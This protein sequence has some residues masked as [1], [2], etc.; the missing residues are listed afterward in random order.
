MAALPPALKWSIVETMDAVAS[1]FEA[2]YPGERTLADF[3]G[4]VTLSGGYK[5]E[6]GTTD[7]V[8]FFTSGVIDSVRVVYTPSGPTTVVKGRDARLDAAPVLPLQAPIRGGIE[9]S[10]RYGVLPPPPAGWSRVTAVSALQCCAALIPGPLLFGTWDYGIF[11]SF[12]ARG[13]KIDTVRELLAPQ[14]ITEV[15]RPYVWRRYDGTFVIAP[16]GQGAAAEWDVD[17][18]E[19]L[20]SDD[21]AVEETWGPRYSHY[22]LTGGPDVSFIEDVW[23]ANTQP[24]T[25]IVFGF[26]EAGRLIS[27]STSV[28][29]GR[30]EDGATVSTVQSTWGLDPDNPDGSLVEL[31]YEVTGYAWEAPM[32]GS[33]F[34]LLNRPVLFAQATWSQV[35]TQLDS[36]LFA[37]RPSQFS[38]TGYDYDVFKISTG[39]ATLTRSLDPE[40][41]DT[42]GSSLSVESVNRVLNMTLRTLLTPDAAGSQAFVSGGLPPG[43]AGVNPQLPAVLREGSTGTGWTDVEYGSSNLSAANLDGIVGRI[44]SE[45]GMVKGEVVFTISAMPQLHRGDKVTIRDLP[46]PDKTTRTFSGQVVNLET[47][48]SEE[49]SGGLVQNV[50]LRYWRAD[51]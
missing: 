2:T 45:T 30:K 6:D 47:S 17:A 16:L 43:G 3:D 22:L 38:T 21:V 44:G 12:A 18:A 34:Q 48:F 14:S 4:G 51:V 5:N 9:A 36:G 40:T 35:R 32:V 27:S 33:R 46:M 10:V 28:T 41:G 7:I 1:R 39:S 23:A 25:S 26:D 19:W 20:L 11:V 29:V 24:T 42:I 37:M 50:T 15:S 8:E 49:Q 31:S 13:H